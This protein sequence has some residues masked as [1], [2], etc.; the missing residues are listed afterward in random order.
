VI[1]DRQAGVLVLLTLPMFFVMMVLALSLSARSTPSRPKDIPEHQLMAENLWTKIISFVSQS[2]NAC[3][4][5]SVSAVMAAFHVKP[6][7]SKA[8]LG[9]SPMI[10]DG[11]D[12]GLATMH[13]ASWGLL[14]PLVMAIQNR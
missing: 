8:P 12:R 13:S 9:S 7:L 2:S 4:R 11:Q 1:I 6:I 5:R 3:S 14:M 10:K